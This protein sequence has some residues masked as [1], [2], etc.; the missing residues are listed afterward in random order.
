[1]TPLFQKLVNSILKDS[2]VEKI[3]FNDP[4]VTG[5]SPWKGHDNHLHVRYKN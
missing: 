2:N 4:N 3:Y 1:M 5:V